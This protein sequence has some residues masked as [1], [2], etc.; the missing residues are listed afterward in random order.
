MRQKRVFLLITSVIL[1]GGCAV[2]NGNYETPR[3]VS[4]DEAVDFK[5]GEK[6]LQSRLDDVSSGKTAPGE[7]SETTTNNSQ[8]SGASAT[9]PV[10]SNPNNTN[11]PQIVIEQGK[12]Y[13]A[14]LHTTVGDI[15]IDFT[16]DQTPVTVNNF[17]FLAKKNFYDNTIF[18]R[19]IKGFMIQGGD[20][21]GNGTGGPGYRF[22]D[23][24][25][26]GDYMRGTVAMA[27]SGPD[28]NGSQFFIMHKD[29]GLQKNYVI[30]GHVTTG[31]DVVDKIAEAPV[32]PGGENSSPV[33][34]I[35]IESVD[36]IER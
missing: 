13:S 12:Q 14:V 26:S 32:K 23:E 34:P 17:I 11:M 21:D 15:N 22:A 8:A 31:L 7:V 10:T 1:F 20:P 5:D 33:N 2:F 25:F 35:K 28:T 9:S 30:F 24:P 19:T 36:V 27:N 3:S 16:A 29:Y 18:H 4:Q 6:M